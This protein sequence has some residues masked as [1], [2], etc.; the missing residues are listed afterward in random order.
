MIDRG[1]T[2]CSC[3]GVGIK[4]IDYAVKQGCNTVEVIGQVL[5]AGTNCGTCRAEI[6]KIIDTHQAS[7]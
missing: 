2:V 6:K 5:Q 1:A 3:F 4:Q 7:W